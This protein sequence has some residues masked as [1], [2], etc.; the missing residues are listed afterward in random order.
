MSDIH[1]AY[2][3][4]TLILLS[5]K[6]FRF[7]LLLVT[8]CC[9]LSLKP[10]SIALNLAITAD[11][12]TYNIWETVKA[13]RSLTK[14]SSAFSEPTNKIFSTSYYS[15]ESCVIINVSNY[16]GAT[17]GERIQNALDDV[18]E[19]GA[20]VF[21]P[22]GI[23]KACNL[24]GQ[25]KTILMGTNETIVRRPVNT[26]SPFITFE[27][28]ICFAVANIIFDGQNISEGTGILIM[29]CTQFE[30][31]NNT[32][33]DISRNAIRIIG[34]CED[35]KI[36][37]NEFIRC[38]IAPVILFGSPSERYIQN[39][40]IVNNFLTKGTDNGKI[41]V[42]FAANG[43]IVNN[44]ITNCEYGIAT[45]CVS[46]IVII[47]NHIENCISYA[48]YLGTQ[49]GDPGSDNIEIIYNY[50]ANCNIG[51]SRYYG[52]QPIHNVTLKN[53]NILNNEQWD[54]YANFPAIFIKNTIT[55]AE[56]LKILNTDVEFIGNIDVEGQPIL[57]GDINN[58]LKIDIR[59]VAVVARL[60]GSSFS[61][62]NWDPSGD[63]IGDGVID[64]KDIAIVAKNFGKL[65]NSQV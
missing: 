59:D 1:N 16:S 3:I 8:L 65:W 15:T 6:I 10:A 46:H 25:S 39:F 2:L 62:D 29:S 42:A 56:K 63:I 50:A 11:K 48:I 40:T 26:T 35:F 53:N 54:I 21:I 33:R 38:N 43:T 28:R 20:I 55:S 37:K 24:T 57:L 36:E 7:L 13:F 12:Q 27:K 31:V 32:F 58:D 34:T 51:I 47:N 30:I 9:I 41:G 64:M 44:T 23:W 45:R 22:G 49:P 61:S 14:A 19:E 18:P 17:D 5:M 4:Y 52:S 60:F